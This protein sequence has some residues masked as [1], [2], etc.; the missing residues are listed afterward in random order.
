[1][2]VRGPER[3]D[4]H[5]VVVRTRVAAVG[6]EE[7][8]NTSEEK[9]FVQVS[10]ERAPYSPL[11]VEEDKGRTGAAQQRYSINPSPHPYRGHT[12]IN[13]TPQKSHKKPEDP[14]N[15]PAWG[16]RS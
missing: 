11:Q 4:V 14:G 8:L 1:M 12:G 3:V 6:A 16:M 15:D 13:P 7:E 2:R 5:V 10:V 9:N